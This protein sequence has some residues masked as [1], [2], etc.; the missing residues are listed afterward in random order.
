MHDLD[1]TF[2]GGGGAG[3]ALA[4]EQHALRTGGVLML[5]LA[6]MLLM[7]VLALLPD[8]VLLIARCAKRSLEVAAVDGDAVAAIAAVAAAVV[9]VRTRTCSDSTGCAPPPLSSCADMCVSA[10]P[11]HGSQSRSHAVP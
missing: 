1:R 8:E 3:D 5:V 6:L 7:L 10:V 2:S 11:A 9:V 4:D